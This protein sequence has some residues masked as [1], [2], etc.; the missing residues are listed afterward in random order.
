MTT[1]TQAGAPSPAAGRQ[2]IGSVREQ[3]HGDN[4]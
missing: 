1:T 4:Q 2:G 3:Q